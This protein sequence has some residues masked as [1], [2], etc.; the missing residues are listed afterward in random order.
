MACGENPRGVYKHVRMGNAWLLRKHMER[1]KELMHKQDAMCSEAAVQSE[2][3]DQIA[4]GSFLEASEK[5]LSAPELLEF[6]STI[7]MLRGKVGIN[8]H[9]YE[10]EDME[11]MILHSKE[12]GFRIRKPA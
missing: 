6:D 2:R 9:C 5:K 11:D 10:P 8:V 12:F 1:A 7:A 3:G 4:I